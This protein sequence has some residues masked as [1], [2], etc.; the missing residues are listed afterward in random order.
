MNIVHEQKYISVYENVHEQL[1]VHEHVHE[2][3]FMN[4]YLYR[5]VQN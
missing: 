4:M 2:M 5:Q 3:L 1:F